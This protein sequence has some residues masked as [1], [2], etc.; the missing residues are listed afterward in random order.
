MAR[1]FRPMV[2]K[3]QEALPHA[4]QPTLGNPRIPN[5]KNW[6]WDHA[7]LPHIPTLA[8]TKK[9]RVGN[10][11]CIP[12]PFVFS[13]KGAYCIFLVCF[14]LA[15]GRPVSL[16]ILFPVP[17]PIKK[18]RKRKKKKAYK[19]Y[20]L[21]SGKFYFS[22][23]VI[24]FSTLLAFCIEIN[25]WSRI[26]F[27]PYYCPWWAWSCSSATKTTSILCKEGDMIARWSTKWS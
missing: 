23:D 19:C 21:I 24:F 14:G 6:T 26:N 9:M 18:K 4:S 11:F 1:P 10:F 20:G 13:L 7:S 17:L 15:F 25:S 16:N 2:S 12:L 22:E 5:A 3:P 27:F 8:L